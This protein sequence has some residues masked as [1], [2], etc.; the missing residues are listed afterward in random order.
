MESAASL[1]SSDLECLGRLECLAEAE[2][3]T[4]RRIA[5]LE[6][7]EQALMQALAQADQLVPA[8]DE[9][10]RVKDQADEAEKQLQACQAELAR[11][12]AERMIPWVC[13]SFFFFVHSMRVQCLY[14]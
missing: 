13:V 12:F 7:K 2:S 14:A 10:R 8:D 4:R 9:L 11:Y 1:C 5:E 6:A 3:C